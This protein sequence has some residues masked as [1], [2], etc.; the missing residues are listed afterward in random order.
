M[1]NF[2]KYSFD[3]RFQN[4]EENTRFNLPLPSCKNKFG[5]PQWTDMNSSNNFT[6]IEEDL[7][8]ITAVRFYPFKYKT[9]IHNWPCFIRPPYH[10][11]TSYPDF[12]ISD[13]FF[14]FWRIVKWIWKTSCVQVW[15]FWIRLL[16]ISNGALMVLLNLLYD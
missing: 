15:S 3:F 10:P 11:R 16:R 6:P 9:Q 14:K 2:W 7:T 8:K 5:K 13:S 4:W 1:L 12:R